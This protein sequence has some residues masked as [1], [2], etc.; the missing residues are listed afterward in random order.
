[1]EDMDTIFPTST[2]KAI[3]LSSNLTLASRRALRLRAGSLKTSLL[4]TVL[5]KGIST[6]YLGTTVGREDQPTCGQGLRTVWD[7]GMAGSVSTGAIRKSCAK[8]LMIF[9]GSCQFKKTQAM[10]VLHVSFS[11]FQWLFFWLRI[12]TLIL[13][14]GQLPIWS[15]FIYGVQVVS[16]EGLASLWECKSWVTSYRGVSQHLRN[17]NALLRQP[18]KSKHAAAGSKL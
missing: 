7:L 3:Y 4:T 14:V 8:V 6:E 16:G 11:T 18:I 2:T 13:V 15:H 12:V 9:F 10:K 1:M 17:S 5:S